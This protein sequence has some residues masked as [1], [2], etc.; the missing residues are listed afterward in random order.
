MMQLD[1]DSGIRNCKIIN[2]EKKIV[3]TD[4]EGKINFLKF[5]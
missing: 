5:V 2:K 1:H 4:E 3:F